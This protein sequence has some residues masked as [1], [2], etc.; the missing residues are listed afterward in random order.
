MAERDRRE[1]GRT[2]PSGRVRERMKEQDAGSGA[3]AIDMPQGKALELNENTRERGVCI[4]RL[5]FIPYVTSNNPEVKP[6]DIWFR[7]AYGVHRNVGADNKIR[8]CL[9]LSFGKP[10]PID[11]EQSKMFKGAKTEEEKDAAKAIHGKRRELYNVLDLDDE[12]KGV[13][14]LD[15]SYHLFGKKLKTELEMA[16]DY[17]YDGFAELKGGFTL[18]CRF[19]KKTFGDNEFYEI[20]RIDFEPRDD[21]KDSILDEAT[22]L[23]TL[24]KPLTY[25][26]L[27]R[28]FMG[29]P[30]DAVDQPSQ[31][32]EK[33]EPPLRRESRREEKKEFP[34]EEKKSSSRREVKEEKKEPEPPLERMARRQKTEDTPPQEETKDKC[35]HG[36]Q[37]G[38][39]VDLH[40]ICATC[41]VYNP[42]GD[43]YDA[44]KKAGR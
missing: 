39:D 42:C 21:Y 44:D 41:A 2:M 15:I 22:D 9:S 25:E 4:K 29:I 18:K 17:A 31:R 14:I 20:D 13:Q 40:D 26:Q 5:D 23:D 1:G 3:W 30:E 34:V 10:C 7:R 6:G 27:E 36:F 37:F 16:E 38:V 33:K 24:L 32:E 11:E 43:K 12:D 35:P 28:E 8:L 19:L